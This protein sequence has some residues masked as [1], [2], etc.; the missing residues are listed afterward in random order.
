MSL[1]WRWA[2][3][4]AT[5]ALAA[6]AVTAVS[7]LV[8]TRRSLI[9]QVDEDLTIRFEL[10]EQTIPLAPPSRPFADRERGEEADDD[11]RI[12]RSPVE[13]DAIIQVTSDDEVVVA[14]SPPLPDPRRD[15]T[16]GERLIETIVIDAH[17][18]RMLSGLVGSRGLPLG[19]SALVQ[20]AR[21]LEEINDALARLLGRVIAIGV[22]IALAA[23][24]AG[25]FLARRA[26]APIEQLRAV[27]DDLTDLET[28]V[29]VE[30]PEDAPGEVGALATSFAAM[31][32]SL[33]SSREDQRRLVA[34]AGH[35]FRTPLTALRTNLELLRRGGDDI[36]STERDEL[37]E[38]ALG[39]TVELSE[40]ATEL[41][42]LASDSL[43][44]TSGVTLDV[45]ALVNDVADRFRSRTN[46]DISVIGPGFDCTGR[47]ARLDRA[48]SNLLDNAVKW[49]ETSI[50]VAVEDHSITIRDDGPGIPDADLPHVFDRFHRSVEARTTPGSGLG[51]AI[52]EHIVMAHG[53]TVFARNRPDGGAEVGF[54]LP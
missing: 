9:E 39:E 8:T 6:V 52:V 10:A 28:S 53:G 26:V 13:L 5:V 11:G 36:S 32:R 33:R 23:G 19:D 44:D 38:A 37:V 34:D 47:P 22:V 31:L 42:D 21:P 35:E 24:A 25:Y 14:G 40:L 16:Q 18:Y 46:A 48:I 1:R 43:A 45:L 49:A 51:L 27:T 3:T 41:V 54:T 30:L 2:I 15:P 4:I 12:R 17:R 20:V 7:A 50:E 29:D